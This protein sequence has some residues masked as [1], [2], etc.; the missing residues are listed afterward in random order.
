MNNEEQGFIKITDLG[1]GHSAFQVNNV[2]GLRAVSML[3]TALAS[4][5]ED[6]LKLPYQEFS[7]MLDALKADYQVNPS[8]PDST[9]QPDADSVKQLLS[10]LAQLGK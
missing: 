3:A 10:L 2:T 7:N 9:K 5:S 4:F 1:E 8:Q 6:E